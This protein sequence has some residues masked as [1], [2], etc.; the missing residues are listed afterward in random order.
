MEQRKLTKEDIDKV[1][2]IEEI[3]RTFFG[4]KK[5]MFLSRRNH[6]GEKNWAY[7][8]K[9][10]DNGVDVPVSFSLGYCASEMITPSFPPIVRY[11]E[12]TRPNNF[13]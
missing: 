1:R 11:L 7:E 9:L 4:E 13:F 10:F 8:F 3:L 12:L 6:G 5:S 2:N